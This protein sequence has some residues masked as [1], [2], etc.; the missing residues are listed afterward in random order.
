MLPLEEAPTKQ[1]ETGISQNQQG[2]HLSI[3]QEY[4]L[5]DESTEQNSNLLKNYRY[6]LIWENHIFI[7]LGRY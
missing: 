5:S 3:E 1:C 7:Y 2:E 4:K 6:E